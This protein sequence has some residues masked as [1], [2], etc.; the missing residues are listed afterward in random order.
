MSKSPR[1]SDRRRGR[2]RN[3]ST[4]KGEA[5][6]RMPKRPSVCSLESLPIQEK[7]VL[8][9]WKQRPNRSDSSSDRAVRKLNSAGS[10][11]LR[12]SRWRM[13]NWRPRPAKSPRSCESENTGKPS[14]F[15]LL[16]T[17]ISCRCV[18]VA[19]CPRSIELSLHPISYQ[20]PKK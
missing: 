17:R 1:A 2:R 15:R 10:A 16:A 4:T 12:H 6:R 18:S 7:C 8:V 5:L 20:S 9:H 3:C 14:A 19:R 13:R 11:L